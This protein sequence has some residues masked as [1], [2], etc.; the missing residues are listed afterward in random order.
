MF[1]R[2]I[3]SFKVYGVDDFQDLLLKYTF[4]E[5]KVTKIYKENNL[6]L[7]WQ[8]K[9]G[10]S[11]LH[12]CVQKKL[13]QSM[14]WLIKNGINIELE[15]ENKET[16]LFYAVTNN[17]LESLKLLLEHNANFEH[18][19]IYKR[20]V[21]Q[22]AVLK[23]NKKIIEI[24]LN[25]TQ[26][27]ENIDFAGHNLIFNALSTGDK[28]LILNIA[29]NK[30]VNLNHA[31]LEKN[32]ILHHELVL[33]D[34]DLAIKLMKLGVNPTISDKEGKNF[35]FYIVKKGI[36]SEDLLDEAL[37]LGCNINSKCHD[38]CNLLMEIIQHI[39]E[40][41]TS[42]NLKKESLLKM[43]KKLIQKGID[44]NAQ[45]NNKETALFLALKH[46]DLDVLEFLLNEKININ[47]QNI[48]GD[49]ALATYTIKGIEFLEELL[50]LLKYGADVNIKDNNGKNIIEKLIDIILSIYNNKTLEDEELS[51]S[52]NTNGQYLVLFKEILENSKV[53]MKQLNSKGKPYFFDPLIFENNILFKLLKENGA[54]INQKDS[55]LNNILHNIIEDALSKYNFSEKRYFSTLKNLILLGADVNSRDKTGSTTAHKAVNESCEQ[56]LKLILESKADV[57]ALDYKG[58]SLVHNCV[59]KN[60]N[61]H[62]TIVNKFNNQVLNIPDSFGI[63][64]INYAAFIGSKELLISLINA[65]AYINNP[66]KKDEKMMQY[67]HRFYDNLDSLTNNVKKDLDKKNILMLVRNMK[68][69]F[70][71]N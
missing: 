56:T 5:D 51:F 59:W 62:F 7:N 6:N 2:I 58:R 30:N 35:L 45:N 37:F 23:N 3:D 65:G 69:E 17:H 25:K 31:D 26:N 10:E 71:L 9:Q 64:P 38:N 28:D 29:K 12:L 36:E 11:Y 66:N 16:A 57:K 22:E 54:N 49:T 18:K 47:H 20:T 61:E 48:D 60:K 67:L 55:S 52:I 21:L 1:G 8:N 27:I 34:D 50:I 41:E 15:T 53:D 68:Q 32:T 70:K 24:L 63:L 40:L 4:Y 13:V 19:N 33:K 39:S 44:I 42:E 14:K 46:K 43:A